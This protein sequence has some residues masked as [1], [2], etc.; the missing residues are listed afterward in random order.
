MRTIDIK[1]SVKTIEVAIANVRAM[2]VDVSL[3]NNTIRL[4]KNVK[5]TLECEL[6][7]K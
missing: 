5:F 7:D 1:S 6:E 4:L 2:E 3:Q